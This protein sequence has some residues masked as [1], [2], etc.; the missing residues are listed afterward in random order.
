M[1]VDFVEGTVMVQ[2]RQLN[3][4]LNEIPKKYTQADLQ[5]AYSR[6]CQHKQTV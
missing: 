3:N 2:M 5:Q 1:S 4:T 6:L